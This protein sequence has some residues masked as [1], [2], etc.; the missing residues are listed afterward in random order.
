VAQVS[1]P[2][3]RS[4][5]AGHD[6]VAVGAATRRL[7]EVERFG[8]GCPV[9]EQVDAGASHVG[10]LAALTLDERDVATESSGVA[11]RHTRER[12]ILDRRSF[13][14]LDGFDDLL[15]THQ[16]VDA[17]LHSDPRALQARLG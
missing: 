16:T 15:S 13:Q 6:Q 17:D 7:D 8:L 14:E 2:G 3:V 4:T 1:D 11:R 12:Q 5:P 10:E 9:G